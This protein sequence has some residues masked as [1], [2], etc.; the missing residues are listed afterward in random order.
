MELTYAPETL[1]ISPL[2]NFRSDIRHLV[3]RLVGRQQTGYRQV[4]RS[5][6]KF[7]CHIR[8]MSPL[9]ERLLA[10][11]DYEEAS[12]RRRANYQIIHSFLANKNLFEASLPAGATPF[13]YPFLLSRP[14]DRAVIARERL[15][16]PT[17]WPEVVERKATG[18]DFERKLV[19]RL[20][21]LPIDHRYKPE[22]M[23]EAVRRLMKA[24]A[25]AGR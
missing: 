10:G 1:N 6:Q 7:D 15:Y 12:R 13:F 19:G 9:S 8:N 17:L 2:P 5:E 21:P 11:I 20:L 3:N 25:L 16:V 24:L 22:H 23:A 14:V 4:R 18:F